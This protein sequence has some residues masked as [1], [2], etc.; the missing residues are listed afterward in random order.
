MLEL[1]EQRGI[2]V[3]RDPKQ[4]HYWSNEMPDQNYTSKH[5]GGC[6]SMK[7]IA[8]FHAGA[9]QCRECKSAYDKKN[10][11]RFKLRKLSALSNSTEY[12]RKWN[13][14]NKE[15][16]NGYTRK[17]RAMIKIATPV[18]ASMREI[19]KM[20]KNAPKGMHVDHVIPIVSDIVCGLHVEWNLQYLTPQQNIDKGSKV[21]QS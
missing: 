14:D 15:L 1:A 11:R 7:P 4:Y 2:V 18:F 8:H 16:K 21:I 12:R 13:T 6:G 5:C 19:K 17:R 3:P 20:Y 10:K 9:T